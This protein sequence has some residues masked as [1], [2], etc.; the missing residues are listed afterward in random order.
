MIELR[1]LGAPDLAGVD[2]ADAAALLGQPKRLAVLIHLALATPRGWHRRDRLVGMLW[3]E[4]DQ[5]RARTALRKTVLTLRETLGREAIVSRGDEEIALAPGA[6]WCDA[7]AADDAFEAGHYA[8]VL[9]LYRRGDLL[10]S[11]Y[12]PGAA[13]FDDWLDRERVALRDKA[14]AAAW[15]LAAFYVDDGQHTIAARFAKQASQLAPTDERMLRRVMQLLERVGDRAGAAAVHD[16]FVRRLRRD[17][18]VEPSPETR[19]LHDRIR[20]A[21]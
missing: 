20:G 12:V 1:L 6:V 17:F 5:E 7:A 13:G 16:D 15:S 10:P 4:L 11:F 19:A 2:P 14:A 18:G 3:P 21:G 9:E 8:R